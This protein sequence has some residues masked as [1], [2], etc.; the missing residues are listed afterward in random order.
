M[1]THS[2]TH[3]LPHRPEDLY[4]LVT[5]ISRYPEF[6]PWCA[7]LRVLKTEADGTVLAEM[8]VRYKSF[9]ERFTS[10]ITMKAP[11]SVRVELVEGPFHHLVNTWEF[12]PHP[13]GTEVVFF[14]DFALKSSMLQALL[15]Y[16][17]ESAF[18]KMVT[19][20][21]ER[22]SKTCPKV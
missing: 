11:E 4:R 21:T 16:F 7:G 3:I 22:A 2:E 12:R 9:T 1:T 15:G 10:R 19:A 13:R 17:F 14:I 5:D 18:H 8:L 20:F 6:L